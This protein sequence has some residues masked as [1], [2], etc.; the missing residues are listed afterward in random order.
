MRILRAIG[1][2]FSDL[3]NGDPVA[4][5]IAGFLLLLIAIVATVWIVDLRRRRREK[6]AEDARAKGKSK[7]TLRR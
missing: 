6:A 7:V 1:D 3:G 4:L 2:F 5:A